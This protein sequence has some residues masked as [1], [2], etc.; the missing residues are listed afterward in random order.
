MSENAN[1]REKEKR[2]ETAERK[3]RGRTPEERAHQDQRWIVPPLERATKPKILGEY[4]L[5]TGSSEV[6]QV[7]EVT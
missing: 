1:E 3:R 7:Q 6:K 5:P 2:K 4:I